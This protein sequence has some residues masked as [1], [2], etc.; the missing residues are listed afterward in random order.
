MELTNRERFVRLFNGDALDRV[1]FMDI[2][3][4]CNWPS[5]LARWKTEGLTKDATFD[6]VRGIIGFDGKRG[7]YLP[8]KT[9]VWP[10]YERETMSDDSGRTRVRNRWGGIE[11]N[12]EGSELMAV[13]ISGAVHDRA[14]WNEVKSRLLAGTSGRF[15]SNWGTLAEEA[16]NGTEPVYTGDLPIGFFGALR[17]LMGFEPLVM[18]FYD[19]PSLI[20]EMLDTLCDMWIDVYA[21]MQDQVKLDY[22]FIWEDMCDKTGP[23]ISPDQFREFL[24]PRYKRF[25]RSLRDNGCKHIMVDSDGDE[26]PLVPLWIEGGVNVVFPWESQFGLDITE[27]RR[28]YPSLGMAGGINKHALAHGRK[29][30][31]DEL[32]KVPFMLESGRYLPG[33][34]HGVTNE[35]SWDNYRYFYDTLRERIRKYP[36]AASGAGVS[37]C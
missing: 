16:K 20:H 23:L 27:V 32:K 22:F 31:D 15:P 11:V 10:E 4:A 17:E 7:T 12:L 30:I 3:G 8:V 26:R 21:R 28:R 19:D 29:A 33:L 34:D 6:T 18:M 36:P 24:L 25:T 2:M 5:A 35:V 9:F 14:S 37:G 1:P 13:T